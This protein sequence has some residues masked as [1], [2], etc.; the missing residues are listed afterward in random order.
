[1]VKETLVKKSEKLANTLLAGLSKKVRDQN[2]ALVEKF[3]S[4]IAKIRKPSENVGDLAMLKDYLAQVQIT[5]IPSLNAEIGLIKKSLHVLEEFRWP[6]SEDDFNLLY[7]CLIFDLLICS[8]N[9]FGGPLRLHTCVM[10]T[11]G[12]IKT[13]NVRFEEELTADQDKFR[14]ELALIAKE[15]AVFGKYGP[16]TPSQV[17]FFLTGSLLILG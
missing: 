13:D 4:M 11:K 2:T 10:E 1:M 15:A 8:Y 5:D 14:T 12:S 6:R 17:Y 16:C 3:D 7:S 9:V